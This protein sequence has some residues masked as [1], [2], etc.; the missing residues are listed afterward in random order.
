MT[1]RDKTLYSED[2]IESL[3]PL[4]FTRKRPGVYAGSVEYSTQLVVELFSNALDEHNLGH[5]NLIEINYKPETNEIQVQDNAQGFPV[6]SW[7]DDEKTVLQASFDTL[8]TSGKYSEDGVYGASALGLNGIGLKICTYL[9]HYLVVETQDG[10]GKGERVFFNEGVFEKREVY[11]ALDDRTGTLVSL[12]P[13]EEFFTHPEPDFKT[14]CKL[15]DDTCGLCPKLDVRLYKN[16]NDWERFSRPEGIVSLVNKIVGKD[17]PVVSNPLVFQKKHESHS[18]NC[19]LSYTSKSGND[20]VA[21][22]N[23]GLT[24]QGPHITALKSAVT[25]VMNKWAREKG[26]LKEKEANIDGASLQE[27]LVLVFN[28]VAPNISYDA[29]TKSRI[30]SNDFVPFLNEVF[31]EQLELWLDTNPQDSQNIIEKALIARKAAEAAKKAREAVKQKAAGKTKKKFLDMPTT[32]VDCKNKDRSQCDLIVVEGKSAA[33]SLVAQRNASTIAVYSVRGM[34]LNLLKCS[35]DKILQNKEINNLITALGLDYDTT[36]HRMIFD[37][38]KL[39]YGRIIAAS[40]ADAAGAEIENLFFN[41]LWKLCPE[42]ILNGYVY[43]AEPPLFRATLK[44][45]SYHFLADQKALAEFQKKH[46]DIKEIHRAK[47]LA[48]Q[49]PE[50]LAESLLNEETRK[51]RKLTVSDI[52]KTNKFFEDLYGKEVRPRVEYIN[53]NPWNVQVDYE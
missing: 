33:S 35:P 3:T 29:Q 46:K 38:T 4:E 28:L 11:D 1:S 51:M 43:S 5:G 49:L 19:G 6:N 18:L 39:R 26:L 20:I 15:F 41:I 40:D 52:E 17:I 32:L 7:R 16:G 9:S 48:E 47:G 21:Y 23:Y 50:Q 44:D 13:S 34:M 22:V 2:S 53:E 24:D 25:R 14:L 30:V 36:K 42:L 31:S 10:S 37:K 8:N 45:N 12:Q 27:G